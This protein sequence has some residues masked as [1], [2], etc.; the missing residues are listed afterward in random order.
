[1]RK[2]TKPFVRF[3]WRLL[4]NYM[5]N[6]FAINIYATERPLHA[7]YLTIYTLLM[8]T[9]P[10]PLCR[11]TTRDSGLPTTAINLSKPSLVRS[12]MRWT[13]PHPEIRPTPLPRSSQLLSRSCSIPGSSMTTANYGGAGQLTTRPGHASSNSS[14]LP[15]KNVGSC[16]PPRPVPLSSWSITPIKIKRSKPLPTL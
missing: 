1:M 3:C 11:K 8:P 6:P 12:K 10:P 16:R 4:M 7:P 13:T 2:P 14:Q 9:F 15:T 5:S